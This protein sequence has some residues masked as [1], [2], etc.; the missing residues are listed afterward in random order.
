LR[1][2]VVRDGGALG[3][4]VDV[5]LG[6]WVAYFERALDRVYWRKRRVTV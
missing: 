6:V 1:S 2:K 5:D 3:S 4:V